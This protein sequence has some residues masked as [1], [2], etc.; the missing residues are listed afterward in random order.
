MFDRNYQAS[1]Y[2]GKVNTARDDCD[3]IVLLTKKIKSENT[4]TSLHTVVQ[5]TTNVLCQGI[6]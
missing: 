6:A 1:L 3:Y 5:S 2:E 4:P